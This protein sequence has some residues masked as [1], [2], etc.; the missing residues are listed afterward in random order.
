MAKIIAAYQGGATCI[1]IVD[2][3]GVSKTAV[4]ELLHEHG[5][6]KRKRGLT[7]Q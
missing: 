7:P 3:H 2:R 4:L 6:A 5:M 1:E